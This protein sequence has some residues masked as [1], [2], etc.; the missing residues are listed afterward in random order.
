MSTVADFGGVVPILSTVLLIHIP[1][2][3]S[4][5]KLDYRQSWLLTFR[6]PLTLSP[7]LVN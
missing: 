5:V 1:N 6:F 7:A 3:P 4:V 2:V